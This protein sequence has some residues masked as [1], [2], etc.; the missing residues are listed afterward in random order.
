MPG[1]LASEV[2][3]SKVDSC[4]PLAVQYACRY[5]VAHLQGAKIDQCDNNRVHI[6]LQKHF[7]HWLEALSL[8]QKISEGVLAIISLESAVTVRNLII[9]LRTFRLIN[10]GQS[11][12]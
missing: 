6:F 7:I 3:K 10:E 12:P 1:I 9:T 11:K 2:E 4:I 5:W 8:M